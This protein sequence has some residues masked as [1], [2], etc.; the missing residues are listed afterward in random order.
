M[1]ATNGIDLEKLTRRRLWRGYRLTTT[2]I[3]TP[4]GRRLSPSSIARLTMLEMSIV[5]MASELSRCRLA[6]WKLDR[7]CASAGLC[8]DRF[9]HLTDRRALAELDAQL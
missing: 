7:V 9:A 2:G 5:H 4:A 6:L 1:D 8:Y 3:V